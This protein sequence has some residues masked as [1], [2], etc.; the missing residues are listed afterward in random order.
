MGEGCYS[1][2]LIK[3]VVKRQRL[4]GLRYICRWKQHFPWFLIYYNDGPVII[5]YQRGYLITFVD[6]YTINPELLSPLTGT[7][8]IEIQRIQPCLKCLAHCVCVCVCVEIY[9]L[10]INQPHID[11]PSLSNVI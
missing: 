11:S 9:V 4:E 5:S 3:V 6:L 8:R 10:Q 1:S 2:L 7:L